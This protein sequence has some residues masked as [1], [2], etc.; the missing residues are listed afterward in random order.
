MITLAPGV[1]SRC[2][3]NTRI[4]PPKPLPHVSRRALA[5]IRH[6]I[7]PPKLCDVCGWL[8]VELVENTEVYEGRSFGEW[9]YC[10]L[11]RS[12]RSYVSLHPHT[13]LPMG[14]MA[15]LFTREARGV[16]KTMFQ[17]LTRAKFGNDRNK[18]YWWLSIAAAIPLELCHFSM[19]DEDT[20]LRVMNICYDELFV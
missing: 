11:C 2:H 18:A 7:E 8:N 20:A 5:R 9:P 19:F 15:D 4:V 6:R 17:T 1:D 3:S 16:A 12:C 14:I 13:D 10:Y